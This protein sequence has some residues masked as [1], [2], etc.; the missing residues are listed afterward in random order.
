M[1]YIF[2][3]PYNSLN[4]RRTV[5]DALRMALNVFFP[6]GR[7]AGD[8]RVA[9]ALGRVALP[10]R[11]ARQYPDQLSGG[12]RQRVSIARALICEP[13]VLICDEVTSALDVSVQASIVHLLCQLQEEQ[14][15]ALLFVTHNLALVRTIADTVM[16]MHGGQIVEQGPADDLID[17]PQH[18]YTRALIADTPTVEERIVGLAR[19]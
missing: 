6:C 9:E 11:V 8:Q 10:E 12:E 2:Q 18:A 19:S 4:P 7:K 16:T 14:D 3:S 5:G 17:R 15:L 1:Q 13:K